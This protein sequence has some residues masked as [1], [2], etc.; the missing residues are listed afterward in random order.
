MSLKYQF[1]FIQAM[2]NHFVSKGFLDVL[3][4]PVT[5]NPGMETHI[6]PF[7]LYSINS[8]KRTNSFLHT[9]P[10]FF[11]KELLSKEEF[12]KIFTITYCFRDEQASPIHRPQF[13]MCE[14]Y[15]KHENYSSIK[16]DVIDLTVDLSQRA[17][18]LAMPVKEKFQKSD[19][20]T[21]TVR[22]LFIDILNIDILNFLNTKELKKL[23]EKNFKSVPLPN[24][25]C[26]WDDYFFLL[27]LNEIEPIIAKEKAIF[28]DE[29]PAPLAAL[30]T[31]K[32]EDKRVCQR[33]ELFIRGVEIA[34]CFNEL[35]DYNSQKERFELQAFEKKEAYNYTLPSPK[36]FLKVI[37]DGYPNSSGI[38]LGIERLFASIVKSEKIFFD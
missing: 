28:V 30:S 3:T 4:P 11:M 5:E 22:E 20:Q 32:P 37:E 26:T 13:L 17:Q 8:S 12:D 1:Q 33:F 21:A 16:E 15:R 19:F 10:E 36:R 25:D 6:H 31:L 18:A 34:N 23:I 24:T 27:F 14:W 35:T 7:E 2:R 38:A 29:Y 9:S